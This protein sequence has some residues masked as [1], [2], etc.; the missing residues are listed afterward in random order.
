MAPVD[1]GG[2][3]GLPRSLPSIGDEV[4]VHRDK[5]HDVWK[6]LQ[7]DLDA[8]KEWGS[9]TLN[10]FQH[11][12]KNALVTAAELGHY[13][14]GEQIAGTC[15]NA[16]EAVGGVYN[17]FLTSY[18][19]VITAIK[20]TAENYDRAEQATEQSAYTRTGNA[21]GRSDATSAG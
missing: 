16:Y 8:L 7:R 6:T 3:G 21:P 11:G 9:G 15:K 5:L 12:S 4:M 14:A 19:D 10:D 1:D 2:G 17:T 20:N 18:Q 13:P